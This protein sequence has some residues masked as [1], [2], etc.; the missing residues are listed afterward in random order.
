MILLQKELQNQIHKKINPKNLIHKK[1]IKLLK[2]DK[3]AKKKQTRL[4]QK[5]Q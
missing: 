3:K 1:I 5:N 4:F 2:T